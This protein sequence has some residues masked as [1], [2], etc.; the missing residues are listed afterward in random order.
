[1][2]WKAAICRARRFTISRRARGTKWRRERALGSVFRR[3]SRRKVP[4]DARSIGLGP[5]FQFSPRDGF[6]DR[7]PS[8][9]VVEARNGGE[10]LTTRVAK[11][12]RVLDAD[13]LKSL[14]AVGGES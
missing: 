1:M 6:D 4:P 11:V 2:R 14:Q 3:P 9:A 10:T 7:D 5:P 12:T 13:F 8:D